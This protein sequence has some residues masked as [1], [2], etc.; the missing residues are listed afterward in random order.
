MGDDTGKEAI[1]EGL[2]VDLVTLLVVEVK[3]GLAVKDGGGQPELAGEGGGEVHGED[4]GS[5]LTDG[6]QQ[7]SFEFGSRLLSFFRCLDEE[8]LNKKL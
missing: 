7:S 6:M 3:V 4:S 5:R 1:C 8:I 2:F